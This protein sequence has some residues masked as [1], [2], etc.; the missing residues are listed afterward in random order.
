MKRR[1]SRTNYLKARAF[2]RAALTKFQD[3][4]EYVK[5][6]NKF[7]A[8]QRE[9]YAKMEDEKNK[10]DAKIDALYKEIRVLNVR[11]NEIIQAGYDDNTRLFEN[12]QASLQEDDVQELREQIVAPAENRF[13]RTRDELI[14]EGWTQEELDKA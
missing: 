9:S 14:A 7:Y 5:R 1:P 2:F 12:W 8:D 3:H 6:K 4:P 10:I 11:R 13:H